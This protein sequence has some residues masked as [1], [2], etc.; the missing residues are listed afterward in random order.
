LKKIVLIFF[1]AG[2]FGQILP[3]VPANIFRLTLY[4]YSM[5]GEYELK[6]QG[7]NMRGI[8]RAYFDD[9]TKNDLG[10]FSGAHDL[11][12]MGD[13][14]INDLITVESY[15]KNINTS[16]GTS[17]PL[18]DAGYY[19]TTRVAIPVGTL[20]ELKKRKEKGRKYRIDYGISNEMMLSI[21]VPN[22]FSLKEEYK[23]SATI[24]HMYGVDN[25]IDYHTISMAK[26]DS[27]FQTT[28]FLML[29]VGKKDTLKMIYDD[30]YSANGDHSVLW[31]LHAK[32]KPFSRGFIDPRFMSPNFSSGDTV[33]FDSLQSYYVPPVRSGSGV[34]DVSMG[35]TVL[36]KG[37]P[38][39]SN[40]RGGVLF[41]RV[42]LS[43]PFGFTIQSFKEVGLKQLSQ[44]NIGSGVSRLTLG[45][46]GGYHWKNKARSRVYGGIDI[47]SSSPELLYTPINLFSGAHTNP[48]S[49]ISKVGETYKL[50]EGNWLRSLL[51]Y[52]FEVSKDRL[53]LKFESRTISK[54]SDD[55]ISLDSGWDKWMEKHKGY[56]SASSSWDIC[57]EAWILNSKSKKRIG[58][59]SFDIVLGFRTTIN[60]KHT[61]SEYKL[62][63][64]ITTYLQSW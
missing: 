29:P 37:E 22:V 24:D 53:L 19:D 1:I 40:K 31:A 21:I 64:G 56:D 48:D 38:S 34:D 28:T 50:K 32:N 33:T 25:L 55:Y 9:A 10:F 51:G 26:I 41:G 46:F 45:L 63:S 49:I 14:P 4:D 15:L 2:C 60:A 8:G 30:I 35:I 59:I 52:E 11:Y 47:I 27:F 3:T 58:P 13:L 17:L 43:I 42:F 7:F 6:D 5:N 36:L 20:T 57:T 44:L 12:H 62:Y 23:A 39:W 61:F 16:Y 54:S 18:F